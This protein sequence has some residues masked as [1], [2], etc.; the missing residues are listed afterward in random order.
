[1]DMSIT[2]KG[3]LGTAFLVGA[4]IVTTSGSS[5]AGSEDVD[6]ASRNALEK[7]RVTKPDASSSTGTGDAKANEAFER[8]RANSVDRTVRSVRLDAHGQPSG[9]ILSDGIQYVGNPN[10]NLDTVVKPGDRVRVEMGS[11][12]RIVVVNTKSML[13]TTLGPRGSV[14]LLPLVAYPTSKTAP[15]AIGGGPRDAAVSSA[16]GPRIDD[17]TELGRYAINGRVDLVL[18]TPNGAPTGLLMDDGTQVQ[19]LPRVTD[20]LRRIHAGDQIRVEGRGTKTAQGTSLWATG[21]MQDRLVLLDL[22]RGEGAPELG[23]VGRGQQ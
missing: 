11:G 20:V 3:F 10:K 8:L 4:A 15:S 12:D 17:A 1:M 6:A 13:G 7:M 23:I 18:T 9:I 2:L 22:E 5:F 16:G 21:I 19:V 14:D